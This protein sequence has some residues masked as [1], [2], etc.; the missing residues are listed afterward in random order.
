ML[1]KSETVCELVASC[2]ASKNALC[3]GLSKTCT[4]LLN[5]SAD[6]CFKSSQKAFR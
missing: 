3:Y 1:G 6:P 4:N 5:M 2:L